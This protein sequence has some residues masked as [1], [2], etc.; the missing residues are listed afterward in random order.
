MRWAARTVGGRGRRDEDRDGADGARP[1]QAGEEQGDVAAAEVRPQAPG[2]R[3]VEREAAAQAGRGAAQG[4]RGVGGDAGGACRGR[5]GRNR[6]E[7]RGGGRA[8]G[9]LGCRRP[10][11]EH[12]YTHARIL[13]ARPAGG[14]FAGAT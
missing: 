2:R 9:C 14:V 7:R 13:S 8:D 10:V 1:G 6:R 4:G 3:F 11:V 5:E 12:A